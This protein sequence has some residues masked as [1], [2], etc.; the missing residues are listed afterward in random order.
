MDRC[1]LA[2]DYHDQG[3][4][5]SQ[6]VLAAFSDLTGLSLQESCSIAGG[7]GG[8]AGTKELCGAI[9]GAVMTLGLLTP[10]DMADPVGSKKRT[11]ALSKEFQTRFAGRFGA[12]RC[13]DLLQNKVAPAEGTAAA[14]LGIK[15]HCSIMI[16]TAVEI[17][18]EML[19]ERA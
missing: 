19:S 4:N 9:T 7:F 6:S 17:V 15:G 2:N 5:C 1:K 8:G 14:R 12:L 13:G 3:F 18:E 10:V 11:V 16:V